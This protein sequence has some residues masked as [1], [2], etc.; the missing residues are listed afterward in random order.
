[1]K[2]ID[3]VLT[4]LFQNMNKAE[5]KVDDGVLGQKPVEGFHGTKEEYVDYG[6]GKNNTDPGWHFGSNK[7]QAKER[8]KSI[9]I[10]ENINPYTGERARELAVNPVDSPKGHKIISNDLNVNKPLRVYEIEDPDFGA[11]DA[12]S[13]SKN[14]LQRGELPKGFTQ[15]DKVAYTNG[16]L[17]ARITKDG[18]QVDIQLKDIDTLDLVEETEWIDNFLDDRGYDGLVYENAFE[19]KGDSYAVYHLDKIKQTGSERYAKFAIPTGG[20]LG[21][22]EETQS[23]ELTDGLINNVKSWKPNNNL[24]T[25]VKTME[26]DPLRVGNVKVKEYDDVGH[27][28]K[29]YGTKSGLLAQDTEAE[30][31][32]AMSNKLVDAN[33]AVDRLVKIDLNKN[34]R[35]ALV[36]LVY[37]VGATGF[38][39]SNALKELNKGN[40]KAFLKEAFDPKVG[41]VR[42]KG[43]IVKGLVNRRARE[44]MIFT[45]GNYGN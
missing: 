18:K 13:I 43:K 34:Q 4:D 41:F 25:F 35:N 36:S 14:V 3:A 17:S 10:E 7:S 37:N 42:T 22:E 31:S 33:K 15:A 32:K 16:T 27:K 24:V 38:G 6:F 30:A 28:A 1:M 2:D 39:K 44:K 5:S 29:G 23:E 11:W 19:G 21:G 40:I 9:D 26:N 8:L 45:K 20:L 12:N